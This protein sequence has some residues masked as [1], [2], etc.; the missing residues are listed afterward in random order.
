VLC[1][2]SQ[3]YRG[4][5]GVEFTPVSGSLSLCTWTGDAP[6]DPSLHYRNPE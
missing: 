5:V 3:R 1:H 2:D 6:P 4:L